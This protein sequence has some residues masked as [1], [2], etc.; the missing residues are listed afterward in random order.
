MDDVDAFVVPLVLN[1]IN[2]PISF[3]RQPAYEAV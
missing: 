1:L 2:D 3:V